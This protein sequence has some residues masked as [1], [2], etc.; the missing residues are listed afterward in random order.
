MHAA[1]AIIVVTCVWIYFDILVYNG[2]KDLGMKAR[3]QCAILLGYW[4]NAKAS[5]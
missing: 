4:G 5:T 3:L 1:C 2:C